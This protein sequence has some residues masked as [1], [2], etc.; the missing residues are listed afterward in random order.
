MYL[1]I[2]SDFYCAVLMV[3]FEMAAR[4]LIKEDSKA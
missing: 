4:K 3:F 2:K 1:I